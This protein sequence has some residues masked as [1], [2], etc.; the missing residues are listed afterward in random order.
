MQC[1]CRRPKVQKY[2]LQ[3]QLFPRS[4]EFQIQ[5]VGKKSVLSIM[6]VSIAVRKIAGVALGERLE[7]NVGSKVIQ[8]GFQWSF[9]VVVVNLSVRD[10][11]MLHGEIENAGTAAAWAGRSRRKIAFAFVANLQ[12][13]YGV[14]DEKFAQRDLAMH[15]R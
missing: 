14:I 8:I 15:R 10:L 5:I 11:R 6:Q 7:T 13:N 2:G 1:D 4:V 3:I 9:P 12:M